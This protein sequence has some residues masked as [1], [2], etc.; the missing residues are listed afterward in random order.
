M[1]ISGDQYT[2]N[3]YGEFVMLRYGNTVDFQARM[4]PTYNTNAT[5]FSAFAFGYTGGDKVT[6]RP[7]TSKLS[8]FS[9]SAIYNICAILKGGSEMGNLK[10]FFSATKL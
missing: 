1:T 10:T 5:Q 3:G 8:T 2:F 6:V 9:L 7:S 4:R